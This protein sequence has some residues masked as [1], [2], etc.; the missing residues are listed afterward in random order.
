M[1]TSNFK[2][3]ADPPQL[4][5]SAKRPAP[6]ALRPGESS[7]P[8]DPEDLRKEIANLRKREANLLLR[9]SRKEAEVQNLLVSVH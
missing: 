2:R 5:G 9:L 7:P 3:P 1:A 8:S 6:A 4:G